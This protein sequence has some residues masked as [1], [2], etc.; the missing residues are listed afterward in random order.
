MMIT[1]PVLAVPNNKYKF[2]IEVDI[3]GYVIG[4]VLSQY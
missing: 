4:G 1:A 2:W 3:S